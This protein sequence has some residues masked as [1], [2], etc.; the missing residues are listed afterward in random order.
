MS[1]RTKGK[2]SGCH[3]AQ[4]GKDDI[5]KDVFSMSFLQTF[6]G[7]SRDV[8]CWHVPWHK[9][10]HAEV[11]YII[12]TSKCSWCPPGVSSNCRI[13]LPFLAAACSPVLRQKPLE[14]IKQHDQVTSTSGISDLD[15]FIYTEIL[16]QITTMVIVICSKMRISSYLDDACPLGCTRVVVPWF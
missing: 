12:L 10:C 8:D 16:H 4:S 11:V 1:Q 3:Q 6:S 5:R 7:T 15:L 13:S 2:D 14:S 9:K